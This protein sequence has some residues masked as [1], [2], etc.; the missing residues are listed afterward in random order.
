MMLRNIYILQLGCRCCCKSTAVSDVNVVQYILL[1]HQITVGTFHHCLLWLLLLLLAGCDP[2]VGSIVPPH[3]IRAKTRNLLWNFLRKMRG[4]EKL[5]FGPFL[6]SLSRA[7]YQ[8]LLLYIDM[9][10]LKLNLLRKG[11]FREYPLK[12][13]ETYS[14][15]YYKYSN[16]SSYFH[17]KL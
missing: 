16:Y 12:C 13:L 10:R 3:L 6:P 11:K 8:I 2:V 1:L 17:C 14:W 5:A 7:P 4:E 9:E 15:F